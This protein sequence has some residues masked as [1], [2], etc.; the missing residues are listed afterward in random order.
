MLQGPPKSSEK[1]RITRKKDHT[2]YHFRKD[3]TKYETS[4]VI[5]MRRASKD[6]IKIYRKRLEFQ[7][8]LEP[9]FTKRK[10]GKTFKYQFPKTKS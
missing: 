6:C 10:E 9:Q 1:T 4:T 7:L 3:F 5:F 2:V 8:L